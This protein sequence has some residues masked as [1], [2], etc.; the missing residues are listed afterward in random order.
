MAVQYKSFRD[1][2]VYVGFHGRAVELAR[3]RQPRGPVDDFEA[4]IPNWSGTETGRDNDL[5]MKFSDLPRWC[6]LFGR[7]ELLHQRILEER[8]RRKGHLDPIMMRELRLAVDAE[9]G[10]AKD[11]A[12]AETERRIACA[13]AQGS[14]LEVLAMFG[15]RYAEMVGNR[16][17]ARIDRTVLL[18]LSQESPQELMRLVKVIV[19]TVV[20]GAGISREALQGR[21][22]TLSELAAPICSIV[23]EDRARSVG[24]LSRQLRLLEA[25]KQ[26][27]ADYAPRAPQEIREA[28]EIIGQNL[29]SFVAYA[30]ARARHIR[31]A[32]LDETFYYDAERYAKLEALLKE[33]RIRIAFALDGWAA[34]ATRWLTIEDDDDA[35]RNAV[36]AYILRQMPAPPSELDEDPTVQQLNAGRAP[37]TMRAT[38]VR[39]MHSWMDDTLDAEIYNR[40]RN[41]RYLASGWGRAAGLPAADGAA[42]DAV[43]DEAFTQSDSDG[44]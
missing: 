15:R 38:A 35:A 20:Q 7:D 16:E 8:K 36:I 27:V 18:S 33:E 17:I 1:R 22:D 6:Q 28:A 42:L 40:V 24:Y 9:A 43:I 29:D 21:L 39:E 3:C 37:M 2:G 14:F 34:H 23:V 25:L 4:L 30:L 44:S 26:E 12:Q 19:G 10:D 31:Q 5:V 41:T 13:D 11:Q 32:I